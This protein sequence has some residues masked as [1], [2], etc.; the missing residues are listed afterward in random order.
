MDN[1]EL[2]VFLKGLKHRVNGIIE[3]IERLEEELEK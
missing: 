3:D 2:K 1:E